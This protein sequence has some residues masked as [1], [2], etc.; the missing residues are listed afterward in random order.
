MAEK[1][2]Q[3]RSDEASVER[4]PS[5]ANTGQEADQVKPTRDMSA[6][7]VKA[8]MVFA[9]DRDLHPSGEPEHAAD[10]TSVPGPEY[11]PAERPPVST[12]RPDE[13]IVT[14]LV[15]GAGAHEPPDPDVYDEMGRWKGNV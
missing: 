3:S 8:R 11:P 15:T 2:Q 14:S 4:R 6:K 1:Q 7:D 9:A 13:P 5:F 10:Q 12:T